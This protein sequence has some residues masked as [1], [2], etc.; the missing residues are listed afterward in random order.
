MKTI[1]AYTFL[2]GLVMSILS[3]GA[4]VQDRIEPEALFQLSVVMTNIATSAITVDHSTNG[5]LLNF[6]GA[7]LSQVLVPERGSGFHHH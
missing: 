6:H 3:A 4:A 2:A 7:P 1:S 5:V